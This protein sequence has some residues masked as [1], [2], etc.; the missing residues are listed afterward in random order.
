M[1]SHRSL[2]IC[3]GVSALIFITIT[4]TFVILFFTVFKPRDPQ[5][6]LHDITVKN[7]N[8]SFFPALSL[9]ATATLVVTIRNQN[10]GSFRYN[11]STAYIYYHGDL[12][13]D[14]PVKP[15]EVPARKYHNVSTTVT[16]D[17]AKVIANPDFLIEYKN[18][19]LT[20][21]SSMA[22]EGKVRVFKVFKHHAVVHSTCE[23]FVFV[24]TQTVGSVCHSK[25]KI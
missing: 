9:N 12:V 21:T 17:G 22:L 16:I 15:D 8:F 10:Y 2:I 1:A 5:V 4:S 11:T 23:I 7:I 13:A 14:A 24:K 18:G 6:F 20:L 19:T 25:L 3:S